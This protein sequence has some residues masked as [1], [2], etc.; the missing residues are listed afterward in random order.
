MISEA[1]PCPESPAT[2]TS[3]SSKPERLRVLLCAY[4]TSPYRGSEPGVGWNIA[5]E[6]A[7]HHDVTVLCNRGENEKDSRAYARYLDEHGPVP[8]LTVHYVER[9]FLTRHLQVERSWR[10]PFYY[11]GY[12]AWQRAALRDAKELHALQPFDV[13]HHLNFIGYREPGFLWELDLPF[14]WGPVGGAAMMPLPFMRL[15]TVKDRAFFTVR[16]VLNGWQMRTR[17]RC[18]DAAAAADHVWAADTGNAKMVARFFGRGCEQMVE[19]GTTPQDHVTPRRFGGDRPLRLVW[20]GWHQARKGL[21]ILLYA[22][23]ALRKKAQAVDLCVLGDGLENSRWKQL[24]VALGVNDQIEWAGMIPH[25]E[26]VQKMARA[27]ALVLT[28]LQEGTPHVVTESLS[29][30]V[31]VLCHDACGMGE[32]VDETCGLKVPMRDI[33][34]SVNGFAEAI[35]TLIDEPERVEALSRGAIARSE[36]LSWANKAARM[37]E[38]YRVVAARS[39]RKDQG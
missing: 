17:R 3:A 31:P 21:P 35:R 9:P 23:A 24:A 19:S 13:A 38:V 16:N 25:D 7:A 20:S 39:M 8:G 4:A 22:L 14:V 26:A 37:A 18:R 10:R 2:H 5:K 36:A 15:F 30:G 27:D 29:E 32:A 11:I 12:K 28:S 33:P 1:G 34:T 6:L